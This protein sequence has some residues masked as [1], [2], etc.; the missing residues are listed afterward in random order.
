MQGTGTQGRQSIRHL[1]ALIVLLATFVTLATWYS[2]VIPAGEGVDETPHFDYVRYV[3]E[4]RALPIQP[5]ALEEGVQVWMGHHPPLYYVLGSIAISWVDTSDFAR[6]FRPNPHFAWAEN[7]GSNGWNVMLHFGQ[8][9]FPWKGAVLAMHVLR[10]MTVGLGTVALYAMYR[11]ARLLFP[12][13][14][15][16]PLGAVALVGLNP[17]FIFMSSTVHHDT[18]QTAIFALATWW[19]LRFLNGPERK[20]DA[21]LGGILVGAA[22]LTK[23]SGFALVPV[24]GL[25]LFLRAWRQ[26]DWGGLPRQVVPL[27]IAVTLIAGWWFVRNQWL[28]GDP[29]GWRMFLNIHRHMVRPG[30][31]TWS[32]FTHEFLGQIGRTFWGAFGYMHITFPEIVKYWWWLSGLAGLGLIVALFRDRSTV[33]VLWPAWTVALAM[34]F[35]LFASF[36]RFSIAT[37]GAGHGRYLFPA[38]ASIGA[39]LIA[40]LN[41]WVGWRRHYVT[42]ILVT[43]GMAAYAVG[44]PL[45]FVLPKYAPPEVATAE[46]LVDAQPVAAVFADGLG[47]IGYQV[48]EDLV[49]PGQWVKVDLWWQATGSA[50]ERPDPLVRLQATD[51]QGNV[52]AS[53]TRWPVPSLPPSVWSQDAVYI[54]H[55]VLRMPDQGLPSNVHL[56]V[57]VLL[58]GDENYLP[59]RA[60]SGREYAGRTVPVGRLLAV[61]AVTEVLP[62]TVPNRRQ[63]VFA[64]SLT[65][66][67]FELPAGPVA[68]NS[69]VSVSLYW[70]V[71]EK[72]AAD[73]T[74]FIHVL[75]DRGELAT[76]FDR[77]PGG[78]T[79]PTSTWLAGQTLRDTYPLPIPPGIPDGVY[80]VRVGMYTWPS[81][82]RLPVSIDGVPVGDSVELG[83]IRVQS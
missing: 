38:G 79:S 4:H 49:V 1:S 6:T 18:L 29:L 58:K 73:Y 50:E 67:G 69:F 65:L 15:W 3:K 12:A 35:L 19:T 34:L 11:A 8:D 64:S 62:G 40:G 59:V 10:L 51:E 39:L 60:V 27:A 56:Q 72:P 53:D 16:A 36:V 81:L 47:L 68:Q 26:R 20:H 55:M 61:G 21:W 80:T 41:G 52:L 76:Q 24:M 70:Q 42:S 43:V 9:R 82:E 32:V 22:L 17:S 83:S 28:Y 2:V 14:P 78:G 44:L 5:R 57:G 45:R 46:Q 7:S 74:V 75:N 30:P 77:P 33:R 63:E 54:T 23:L 66:R 25:A 13:H 71:L 31:Y 48:D 37:V